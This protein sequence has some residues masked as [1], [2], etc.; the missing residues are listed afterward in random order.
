MKKL[1]IIVMLL[2]TTTGFSEK[3]TGQAN[4]F[5]DLSS[6]V[7]STGQISNQYLEDLMKIQRLK[8]LVNANDRS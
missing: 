8:Y 5:F 1:L 7:G 2:A 3:K 4:D 6:K